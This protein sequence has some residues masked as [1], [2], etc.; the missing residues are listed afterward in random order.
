M[1]NAADKSANNPLATRRLAGELDVD[2]DVVLV[3]VVGP[4]V[5][6]ACAPTPPVTGPVSES[7]KS[8]EEL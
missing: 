4:G 1:P 6:V 8:S 2:E 3:A 5:A 7:W